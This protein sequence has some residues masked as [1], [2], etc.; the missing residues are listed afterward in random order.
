MQWTMVMLKVPT[1]EARGGGSMDA[2]RNDV[3]RLF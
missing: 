3:Y 1:L 2:P